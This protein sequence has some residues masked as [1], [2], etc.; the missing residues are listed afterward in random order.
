MR[1]KS[2]RVA[3]LL[4][5]VFV[6]LVCKNY[7]SCSPP[8]EI[9]AMEEGQLWSAIETEVAGWTPGPTATGP[10]LAEQNA[11]WSAEWEAMPGSAYEKMETVVATRGV[12]ET[13]TAWAKEQGR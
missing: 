7:W 1:S 5:T 10:T 6:P 2:L 11:T 12:R 3:I 13:S 9:G 4:S 8:P